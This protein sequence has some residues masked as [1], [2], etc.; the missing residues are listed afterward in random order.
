MP[1]SQNH[2]NRWWI[3]NFCKIPWNSAEI[4]KFYGKEK[5]PQP[6]ENCGP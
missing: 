3:F 2:T 6:T 4:S 5:I 1:S